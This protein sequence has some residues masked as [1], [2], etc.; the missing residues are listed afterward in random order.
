MCGWT[1]GRNN[2]SLSALMCG[3][4][5]RQKLPSALSTDVWVNTPAKATLNSQ[6]LSVGE[7]PRQRQPLSLSAGPT[8]SPRYWQAGE[9]YRRDNFYPSAPRRSLFLYLSL[10]LSVCLSLSLNEMY[11]D[12]IT[13]KKGTLGTCFG[14]VKKEKK[15]QVKTTA[16]TNNP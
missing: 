13:Y 7:R 1:P 4:T 5:P 15:I 3:W 8:V 12:A 11:I 9:R 14:V 6:H 16:T 2:P 10:S